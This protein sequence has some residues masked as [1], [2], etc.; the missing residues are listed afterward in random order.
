MSA[1]IHVRSLAG[2]CAGNVLLCKYSGDLTL[3]YRTLKV[4]LRALQGRYVGNGLH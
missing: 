4:A 2:S 1:L 3:E